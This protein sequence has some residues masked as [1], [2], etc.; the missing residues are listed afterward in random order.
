MSLI[1]LVLVWLLLTVVMVCNG[2]FRVL[3]LQPR[4]GDS[5]AEALSAALGIV[6]I[7]LVTR[8]F[9]RPLAGATVPEVAII[10]VAWVVLTVI[11]EF[12]FG[13]W[14]D[15]KSWSELVANYAIWRGRLWLLVLAALAAAPF[16][17]TRG[18]PVRSRS[19]VR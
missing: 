18:A 19:R 3:V 1:K 5:V 2:I 17:W 13:H 14:V 8:P 10:S 9:L 6:I 12:T 16:I 11:F 15:R 4:F 7:L